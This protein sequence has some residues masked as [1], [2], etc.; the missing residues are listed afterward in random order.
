MENKNINKTIFFVVATVANLAMM[1]IIFLLLSV[2]IAVFNKELIQAINPLWLIMVSVLL[3]FVAYHLIL[4]LILK[5]TKLSK[6]FAD[7]GS[8]PTGLGR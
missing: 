4:N 8:K 2:I 3:S 5:K 6:Y 7:S 1:V